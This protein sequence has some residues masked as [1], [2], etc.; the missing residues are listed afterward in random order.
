VKEIP[1]ISKS[2]MK[3]ISHAVLGMETFYALVPSVERDSPA[4]YTAFT[5]THEEIDNLIGMGLLENITEGSQ[6]LLKTLES[7]YDRTVRVLRVTEMGKAMFSANT[8]KH[9]N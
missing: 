2:Q 7:T 9:V 8:A 3:I 6:E 5:K 4:D 1:S